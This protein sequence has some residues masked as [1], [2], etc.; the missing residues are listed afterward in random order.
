[1]SNEITVGLRAETRNGAL[2]SAFAPAAF[3]AD[4]ATALEDAGTQTI[5]LAHEAIVYGDVVSRGLTGITNLSST[6]FVEVGIDVAGT[7]YG[8]HQIPPG[9]SELFWSHPTV[10]LYARADTA[11]VTIKT[12]IQSR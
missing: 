2:I 4:Q 11:P 3:R 6:D 10:A 5:G 8:V 1:M 12:W 7:F 9:K